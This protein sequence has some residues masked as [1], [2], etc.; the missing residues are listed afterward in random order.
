MLTFGFVLPEDLPQLCGLVNRAYR[1]DISRT[2]WT[3]EADILDGLRTTEQ[4]LQQLVNTPNSAFLLAWRGDVLA[5][6]IHIQWQTSHNGAHAS[7]G[8]FV[9]EPTLQTH[10]IGKALLQTAEN[11]LWHTQ[12]VQQCH[13]WVIHTRAELIAWY[14]RRGYLLSGQ[15][16]EFPRNDAIW[17][18][19]VAG[20]Q[21]L[22]LQKNLAQ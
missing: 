8:M 15:Q 6:S 12:H 16:R 5:G 13:L 4:E 17:Q 10:G 21:L 3:T 1:G 7:L 22:H 18:P 14:Q 20:L 11:Y 19:K 2:G 9:V